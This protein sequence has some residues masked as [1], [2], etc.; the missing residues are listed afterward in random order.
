MDTEDNRGQRTATTITLTVAVAHDGNPEQLAEQLARELYWIVDRHP[1]IDV[2]DGP[3]EK[4]T[5]TSPGD[6]LS[7]KLPAW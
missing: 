2:M 5:K 1:G 6:E 7:A 3:Y 4:V